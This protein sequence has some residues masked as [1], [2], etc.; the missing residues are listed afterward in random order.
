MIAVNPE[1][2]GPSGDLLVLLKVFGPILGAFL[3]A[4]CLGLAI[5]MLVDQPTKRR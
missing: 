2:L 4:V 5:A 3:C 1:N